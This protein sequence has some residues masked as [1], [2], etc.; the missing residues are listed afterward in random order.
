MR[1]KL[2]KLY[3]IE[4]RID[5]IMDTITESLDT[6]AELYDAIFFVPCDGE[7]KSLMQLLDETKARIKKAKEI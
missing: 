1:T 7:Q 6:D 5:Y 3:G 4:R 2:D